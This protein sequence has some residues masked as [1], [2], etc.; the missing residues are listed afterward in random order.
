[1]ANVAAIRVDNKENVVAGLPDRL[2]PDLAVVSAGIL[3]LQHGPQEDECCIIEPKTSL[4]QS[5]PAVDVIPLKAQGRK[6]TL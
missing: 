1:M 5:T 6:Y 2:H 3:L 4:A